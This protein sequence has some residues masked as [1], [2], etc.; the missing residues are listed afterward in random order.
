[1]LKTE[2]SV[3]V[4]FLGES[5]AGK[6]SIIS[7][8][9][10]RGT[11]QP[12]LA[13][14]IGASVLNTSLSWQGASV[15]FAIW[16]TAGQ[17]VYHSL[18]PMYYRTAVVAIVVFD[19]A[20]QLSYNRVPE[21]IK[22][23]NQNAPEA[24]VIICGNK[25]DLE[26]DRLITYDEAAALS[27]NVGAPYLETSAKTGK[28]LDCLFQTIVQVVAEKRPEK[29]RECQVPMKSGEQPGQEGPSCC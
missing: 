19:I 15:R 24:G 7:S 12:R 2:S 29:L 23:L 10:L 16:D 5:G 14:T 28:G 9:L 22:E 1:M 8:H 11:F 3:R 21:W 25:S 26:D 6:T 13:P 17:E 4:V 20:S 18:T 27:E